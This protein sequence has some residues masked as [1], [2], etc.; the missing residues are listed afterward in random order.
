MGKFWPPLMESQSAMVKELV[1]PSVDKVVQF[2]LRRPVHSPGKV[3]LNG[4]VVI[5]DV[6]KETGFW[7]ELEGY[8][9]IR[10]LSQKPHSAEWF[11]VTLLGREYAQYASKGKP[12]RWWANL[13]HDLGEDSTLRSKIVWSILSVVAS[14]LVFMGMKL[15]GWYD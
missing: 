14:N 2:Q 15:L 7:S 9:L 6:R 12:G 8:D 4:D 5:S 13:R 3:P 10:V 1:R 11:Y